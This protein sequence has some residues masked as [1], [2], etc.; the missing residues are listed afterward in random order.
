MRIKLHYYQHRAW[1]SPK[2]V[3]V[4]AA[5]I[6]SGKTHIGPLWLWRLICRNKLKGNYILCAPTYKMLQQA[7]LPKLLSFLKQF[8]TYKQSAGEFHVR[9]GEAII[10][11][12]SLDNPEA[13]EGIPDVMGVWLDEGGMI[14]KY[15]WENV[16]G[17]A[18]RLQAP[19]LVTTTPYALNWLFQMYEDVRRKL[20][21]DVEFIIWKSK[22]SPYFPEEEYERQKRILDPRRFMMKYDGVFGQMEGLVYENVVYVQ[23]QPMPAGTKYYAGVDWGFTDPWALTIRALTPNGDHYQISEFYKSGQT[24]TDII[25]VCKSRRD[26][27]DI[28]AFVCDPSRPD[29]ILELCQAGLIAIPGDN[30]ISHGIDKHRELIRTNRFYVVE[31]DN[32]H[33]KD[34]YSVYHYPE[35]KELKIDQDSKDQLPVDANNHLMDT[36]RY[37]TAYIESA[38]ER[39]VEPKSPTNPGEM[40]KDQQ[41]RLRW[42]K[43]GGSSRFNGH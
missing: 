17:R 24:I 37:V 38:V 7:S 26:M 14:S 2:R 23:P 21:D 36:T 12:R 18:A 11:V 9:G 39:K 3:V 1:H 5:G 30:R 29:S 35:P 6:Q 27:F 8:G 16:E 20:R 28:K 40:P 34:E 42:L 13:M 22:D 15:A 19:I 41:A 25:D 32:P 31:A 43:K 10:Y 4:C 33:T